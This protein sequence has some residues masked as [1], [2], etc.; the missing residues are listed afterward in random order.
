M[1]KAFQ[2]HQ[3]QEAYQTQWDIQLIKKEKK[4]KLLLNV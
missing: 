2:V 4:L 3:K 1:R